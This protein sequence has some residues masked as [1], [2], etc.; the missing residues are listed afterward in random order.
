MQA[1][2]HLA[3]LLFYGG[4]ATAAAV[5]GPGWALWL[6]QTLAFAIAAAIL[7]GG[8]LLHEV[9]ARTG[10]ET[11][12][13][14]QLLSLG[15]GYTNQ[16]E[17]LSWL[18]REVKTLREG[19]ETAGESGATRRTLDEVMAEVKLI[20]S[21]VPRLSAEDTFEPGA[22]Q[23]GSTSGRFGPPGG[24]GASGSDTKAAKLPPGA[25]PPVAENLAPAAILDVVRA[26]LRD[27]RIDLVLQPIV[28]LPQRKRRFYEC[29]SRLRTKDG[30]MILPDKYIPLAESQGLI[31]AI[32]N[33]LLFK[34]VQLIRKIHRRNEKVDFFCN[35]SPHSLADEGFFSDF[36][37]F[38]ESNDELADH[39][40]FEFAQ[41]DF[42]RWSEAGAKL[43]DRLHY[44]GCRFSLDQ[45]TDLN[46]DPAALEA[47]HVRFVKVD[48]SLLLAE[49][50]SNTGLMR[51][52]RRH[53]VDL[54][55]Q[56]VEN[57]NQ[58]IEL[59][60]YDIDYGQGFLFGE[61]R[62]A[63]PAA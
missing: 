27:D 21:L 11:Y 9:Y 16:Q 63:R 44:L 34:C 39:L 18:R 55:V 8:G 43:L 26:S 33:M 51:A 58:M 41:T 28:S 4:M 62:L 37:E 19:L 40:V 30:A 20:K 23:R 2:I 5:Y 35:I 6:D 36:V 60:E 22:A 50:D 48:A 25:L 17:E 57:E 31:T 52:L 42:A 61:P 13:G 1:L 38:L 45:V 47:R 14:R 54:I 7:V 12:L 3:F 46:F 56:K 32:D 10:R 29:F 49:T 24:G 15:Y 53:G 59:L